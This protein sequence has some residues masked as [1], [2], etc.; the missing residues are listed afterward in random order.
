MTP[1]TTALGAL[2]VLTVDGE[3]VPVSTAWSD[4]PAVMVWL[5]HFG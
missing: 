1:D 5:R 4:G 3:A 2:T